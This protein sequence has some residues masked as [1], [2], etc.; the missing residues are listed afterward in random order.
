MVA[1]NTICV[2][3]LNVHNVLYYTLLLHITILIKERVRSQTGTLTLYSNASLSSVLTL[4]TE[5]EFFQI[6]IFLLIDL[7]QPEG[8]QFSR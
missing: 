5:Q 3:F 6:Y 8:P 7:L 2:H 1:A 4:V